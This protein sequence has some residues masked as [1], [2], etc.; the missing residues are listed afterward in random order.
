MLKR[1]DRVET[2]QVIMLYLAGV[3]EEGQCYAVSE[4]LQHLCGKDRWKPEQLNHEGVSH[5]YLRHRETGEVL[6][7][8]SGQFDTPVP[9]DRG[10]GRGFLTKKP[11]E[12]AQKIINRV[13]EVV[14]PY[15]ERKYGRRS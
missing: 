10:R 8:T 3:G 6:D 7:L 11:S 12:K 13:A 14:T 15:I 5:W 9:Y 4:A 2:C 1:Y